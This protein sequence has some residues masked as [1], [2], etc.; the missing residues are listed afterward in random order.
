MKDL[1]KTILSKTAKAIKEYSKAEAARL[2][3]ERNEERARL[4]KARL[5]KPKAF[6]KI[7]MFRSEPKPLKTNERKR[8][9]VPEEV[10]L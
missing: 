6:G 8:V 4:I 9:D 1:E 10:Q 7:D 2:T 3:D 5:D